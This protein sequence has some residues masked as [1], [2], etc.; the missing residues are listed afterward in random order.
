MVDEPMSPPHEPIL[1]LLGGCLVLQTLRAL[2]EHDVID[3]LGEKPLDAGEIAARIGG[4]ARP[5]QQTLRHLTGL[6][7]FRTDGHGRYEP[8][9]LGAT[10]AR[11]H[12]SHARDL[13][14]TMG[15]MLGWRS[16]EQ[17]PDVL[18]T[19]RSGI[20]LAHG[21]PLFDLL[22]S[23][24]EAAGSF[25]GMMVAVA[26][27]E[28]PAVA[29]AYDFSAIGHLVDVGGGMGST[30]RAIRERHPDV[31]GTLFDLPDVVEQ[32]ELAGAG[33]WCATAG[34]SFLDGVP[35]GA[36]GYLLSHIV[37][38]W[39]DD[40]VRTILGHCRDG[41]APGGRVLIVETVLPD[42]DE[43]HLGK[44]LDVA[45]LTFLGAGERT[46]EEYRRLLAESGLELTRVVPTHS[47]VSVVE[48]VPASV[49]AP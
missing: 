13:V 18:R 47:V 2:V 42:D 15:G 7:Y 48:A 29:A 25:H 30:L 32:A 6:G 12:P 28:A 33:Q 46:A 40:A 37:H 26:G 11:D 21:R 31:C 8:T 38:N 35:P 14:R 4:E 5:V 43:P 49:P 36:D 34:G 9:R 45:M 16:M 3:I 20:E 44:M 17:L 10:L 27:D 41:L 1:H 39:P 24:P 19:G 23:D 22:G